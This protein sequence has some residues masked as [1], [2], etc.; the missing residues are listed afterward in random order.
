MTHT[1]TE[2]RQK[3]RRSL[4]DSYRRSMEVLNVDRHQLSLRLYLVIVIAHWAEHIVQGAQI[5]VLDW[6]L[7]QARG[8]L[9]MPFPWLVTSEWMHYGYALI[10]L[11]GLFLLL[12]GFTG[13]S[14]TWWM[15]S[16]LI[17]VWHHFEH[18]LLLVQ[19]M[20]GVN[21]AGKDSP[22]S[23]IELLIPRVEL[24]LL[25]NT[26]VFVPMVVAMY[27][28]TRPNERDRRAMLCSCAG[29][30]VRSGQ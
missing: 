9:G 7:E 1:P 21:I 14:R 30:P 17:Q 12:P 10:M 8:L 22:T 19:A 16:L 27:L 25:Y 6:P 13:R 18:L 4:A 11:I 23:L 24:H 26:I 3:K 20:S 5:Y 2:P 28:H 29:D 15:A